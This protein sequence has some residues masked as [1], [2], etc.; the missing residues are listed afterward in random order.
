MSWFMTE[1]FLP[2]IFSSSIVAAIIWFFK[3]SIVNWLQAGV[4]HKF[5]TK[6]ASLE[7]KLSQNEQAYQSELAKQDAELSAIR[8][9]VLGG[10]FE[11]QKELSRRRI[12]AA[13]RLWS[14]VIALRKGLLLVELM[15]RVDVEK[16]IAETSRNPNSRTFFKTLVDSGKLDIDAT[17]PAAQEQPFL[18]PSIVNAYKVYSGIIFNSFV[19]AVALQNGA[20]S[21]LNSKTT[22]LI[23]E[24]KRLLPQHSEVLDSFGE[25]AFSKIIL[26]VERV[27][28]DEIRK[29]LEGSDTNSSLL[30]SSLESVMQIFSRTS[31]V[32]N[33]KVPTEFSR[34]T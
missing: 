6:L 24:T 30:S 23:D 7:S 12:L 11:K 14:S 3:T 1:V 17:L 5:N 13:E 16:A 31:E 25:A 27:L 10:V 29:M 34:T 18:P 28:E 20:G 32:V 2:S 26:D 8:D 21:I 22:T 19:T 33:T 9:G 4:E 15:S